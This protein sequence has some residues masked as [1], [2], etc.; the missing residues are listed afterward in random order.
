MVGSTA[1]VD[2]L[3]LQQRSGSSSS[4]S[5]DSSIFD[6]GH[7]LIA[8]GS[9]KKQ[10]IGLRQKRTW[11]AIA[12]VCGL[13]VI[14]AVLGGVLGASARRSSKNAGQTTPPDNYTSNPD[15]AAAVSQAFS[16]AWAGYY[17]VAFPSDSLRPVTNGSLN[18]RNGW[19]A[20]AID[21]LS[22]ALIMGNDEVVQQILDF[23]PRIDFD[24]VSDVERTVSLF[25]STIRY[26]GG[27][28]SAHDLLS[29]PFSQSYPMNETILTG[30]LDQAVHLAENLKVAFNTSSGVPI[31]RLLFEPP[32]TNDDTQ[33]SLAGAGTL[34]L[35][36]T[37]LSD[38]TGNEEYAKL[39]E[40][41]QSYL[42]NPSPPEIA[43]PYPGLLGT[44]ISPENGSFLESSGGWW[45]SDDSYYEYLLKMYMYDT[46]RF[47][48]YKDKWT[49]A[50]DS[51]IKYLAS[52]PST[53]PDLTFLAIYAGTGNLTF[54]SGH[55][56]CFSGGTFILGGLTLDRQDYVDFGIKL[57]YS[58]HETY[59]AT[60]TGIGPES[61]SWKDDG[62]LSTSAE[63]AE[64][65]NDQTSFY[66]T[67]G[68]WINSGDYQLRPEAIE[69]WY[70]AY[71]AT[72][73]SIYQDWA[74]D[75]FESI[76]AACSAGSGLSAISDVNA[77]NGGQLLN[78]QESFMFAETF[79]YLYMIQ[80]EE[81][82]WQ[83]SA[84]RD[85]EFVY[86]TE[87]HPFRIA[88]NSV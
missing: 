77:A 20:T 76:M 23:I 62:S 29:G 42:L 88:G 47:S 59:T 33:V 73:N 7:Q 15:R 60:A 22:T 61:F 27:L 83:V 26:I 5:D 21:A 28:L 54:T 52:H 87:A 70:Y 1:K 40:K 84:S 35:E 80:A 32:R 46:Q 18:D 69:S 34:I 56:A 14:A 79:K 30:V 58:C 64:P 78:S 43:E 36:W 11:I 71:R 8:D 4:N 37:R 9:A 50:A 53:R 68:F 48:N 49:T 6:P 82:P 17:D 65:P 63:I 81:A 66:E 3:E 13:V 74:W 25:E 41:A 16:Q 55:L 72:G 19:G 75:A 38:K 2:Q 45:G 24:K 10:S 31:G 39:A 51:T 85:N 57:A 67:S 44:Y 12:A 86:N